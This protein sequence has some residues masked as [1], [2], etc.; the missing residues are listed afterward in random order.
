MLY[1]A[2]AV[3]IVGCYPIT[4]PY[5]SPPGA[6]PAKGQQGRHG[7]ILQTDSKDLEDLPNSLG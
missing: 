4:S 7:N 5:I 3:V 2:P 6:T 1:V